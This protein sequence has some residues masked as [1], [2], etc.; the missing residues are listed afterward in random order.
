[1]Q[2]I[3]NRDNIESHELDEKKQMKMA[4]A[5]LAKIQ[6]GIKQKFTPNVSHGS[7]GSTSKNIMS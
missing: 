7:R 6:G 2:F 1:M 3:R 4:Q 5:M